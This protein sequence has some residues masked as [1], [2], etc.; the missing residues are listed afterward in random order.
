MILTA[1][2][3][4]FIMF[5]IIMGFGEV[6]L[7]TS[8]NHPTQPVRAG[9]SHSELRGCLTVLLW[10]T[11]VTLDTTRFDAGRGVK[12]PVTDI[13]IGVTGCVILVTVLYCLMATSMSM[14]L[15]YDLV[16]YLIC[17]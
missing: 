3:I 17:N 16:M 14:L 5:V 4:I 11:L 13:P 10:F 2:H 1:L 7:R 9:S 8:P 12:N 15:P 6:T